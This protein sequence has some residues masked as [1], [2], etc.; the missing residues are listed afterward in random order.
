MWYNVQTWDPGHAFP[1]PGSSP[2]SCSQA[3]APP[4][5]EQKNLA[6]PEPSGCQFCPCPAS[7]HHPKARDRRPCACL[8][9]LPPHTQAHSLCPGPQQELVLCVLPVKELKEEH[10]TRD[11][12]GLQ[13]EV[14]HLQLGHL[15]M[16]KNGKLP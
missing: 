12:L 10:V 1:T 9:V 3:C 8:G 15:G 11:P 7:C 13:A 16:D 6:S 5:S 4:C 14:L 2:W